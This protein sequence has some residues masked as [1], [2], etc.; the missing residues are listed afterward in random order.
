ML[1][2][3]LSARVEDDPLHRDRYLPAE[4]A[5]MRTRY[6]LVARG[7]NLYVYEPR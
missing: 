5:A 1:N 2:F 6:R 7:G 4:L 3:P